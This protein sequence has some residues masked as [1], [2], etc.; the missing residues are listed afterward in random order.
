MLW[1]MGLVGRE[2]EVAAVHTAMD[3]TAAGDSR[4]L[5][6]LGEAGIGKTRLLDVVTAEARQQRFEV[7]PGRATEHEG[8]VPLSL[9]RDAVSP[10]FEPGSPEAPWDRMQLLRALADEF[11][12]GPAD[13]PLVLALD[14][15]HWADPAS[16][17][18]LETLVRR[19]PAGAHLVVLALRPGAVADTLLSAARSASRVVELLELAPL[20]REAA[21]ELL[22]GRSATESARLYDA[23]GGNPLL[24]TEL[25]RAG[26]GEST[27]SGVVAAVGSELRHVS[28]EARALV[29]AGALLG[30]PFVVDLAAATASLDHA[31]W[32]G[33]L[34]ELVERGLLVA[35]GSPREF[36]FRHP[37]VRSAVY[38]GISVGAR[39]HAHAR[40]AE[41]LD[42]VQA[43][44]VDRARHLAHS[45]VP[46]DLESAATLRA[47]AATVR[48]R[49]PSIAADWL[50][51]AK[52]AAPPR[53]AA[54]F[55]DLAQVL[56]QSGRLAEALSAAE[57]GL[58]FGVGL[59]EAR[60]RLILV[61]A[62]VE[63][64]LGRHESARRR[65]VRALESDV[66]GPVRTELMGALAL[67]AY[68][69]G[70][71][72]AVATWALRLHESAPESL[73]LRAVGRALLSMV[74]RFQGQAV[75]SADHADHAITEIRDATDEELATHAE[76][77][78]AIPWVLMAV[79][80]FLPAAEISRRA[81]AAAR[82]AGN[83]SAAVPLGLPEV[84]ALA[85][86]GRLEQA[87]SAAQQAELTARLTHNAQATQWALWARA[88]VLLE[89]GELPEALAAATESVT[90]AEGLDDSALATVG[91]TV[92]GSV[93]LADGRPEQ[94]A[95]LLAAYDVEPTWICRWA[96]RLV[97]ALLATSDAEAAAAAARHASG[98]AQASGLR[99]AAAAARRAT[100][101]V[102]L[103]AG[104][105]DLALSE[106]LASV[107][108][109][110]EIGA[111]HDCA[112]AHLL[113][114]RSAESRE[115]AVEHL[116]EAHRLAEQCGARRTQEEAVR[117]LRRLGRRIGRGGPRAPGDHGVASLSPREREISDLVAE[118]RT[119]REI[120]ARL[121]LSEKT[122][123]SHLSKAFT[124]LGVTSRTALAASVLS[125][126]G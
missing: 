93:L 124:K 77:V 106:A 23:S 58:S 34:D 32:P 123:E 64:Q 57:E 110:A 27:P 30:D 83:L 114:G 8:D 46:G 104:D 84:L 12:R 45:A 54:D 15:V 28:A 113:A 72:E 33:A 62:S 26:P 49:A 3:A 66:S 7:L 56:V 19:P 85:L 11:D 102:A 82:Q 37:V 71:Y 43:P 121:F 5:V 80:R 42:R 101:M 20:S 109:A 38:D 98:L 51:V 10:A 24:L 53:D 63:R 69:S 52:R 47:A 9:F 39:L 76:L 41:V 40:A 18:L 118:G 6:L 16:L 17:D 88:W 29:E 60:L 95:E 87:D 25:N 107:E 111:D 61:A 91:R 115:V 126:H 99:G 2:R 36:R 1:C 67:S 4:L 79:E 68:E 105:R 21:D 92:L 112:L 55:G 97:E 78:T 50:L 65:L 48:A 59:A 116:T 14:D 86:L 122:V 81:A 125:E 13:P 96:P 35:A 44:T 103:A 117:E 119:N 120:A 90:I 100:G 74:Q 108:A 75:S 89:R 94:A 22:T 73:V 31:T 70:D